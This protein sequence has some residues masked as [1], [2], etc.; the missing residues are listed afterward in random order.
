MVNGDVVATVPHAQKPSTLIYIHKY[1][2][3]YIYIYSHTYIYPLSRANL[4][5]LSHLLLLLLLFLSR[6]EPEICAFP[7]DDS[8]LQSGQLTKKNLFAFTVSLCPDD[9]PIWVSQI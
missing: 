5:S 9:F 6:D 8:L 7:F 2:Y 3:I 1:I 4:H